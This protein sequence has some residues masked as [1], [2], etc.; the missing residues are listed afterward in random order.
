MASEYGT[1]PGGRAGPPGSPGWRD[2]LTADVRGT[3]VARATRALL[4]FTYDEPEREATE[5]LLSECL[6]PAGSAVDPQVRALAV[7]CVGHVA[8]I[9]GEV[10]P[11]LVAR[12]RGLLQDPV[13]GGRAEDALD[14]VASFA[15]H[16]LEPKRGT[17]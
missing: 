8:R 2:A 3:D 5:E 10:G 15:P 7:T 16:A 1:P 12:V 14:D 17:D 13:L 6:D 11:D 9:H 4:A